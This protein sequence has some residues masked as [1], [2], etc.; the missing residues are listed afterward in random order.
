M[1][2]CVDA[3]MVCSFHSLKTQCFCMHV[4]LYQG[5]EMSDEC[6]VGMVRRQ[7]V[8]VGIQCRL[9]DLCHCWGR[10]RRFRRAVG[11]QYL[12]R[13]QV[14]GKRSTQ[15]RRQ[16]RT[17]ATAIATTKAADTNCCAQILPPSQAVQCTHK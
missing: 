4:V 13:V 2:A 16:R 10:L 17:V 15:G 5:V 12:S 3:C 14:D 9:G 7:R 1:L 6:R 11:C 8:V